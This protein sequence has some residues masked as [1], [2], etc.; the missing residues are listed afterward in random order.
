MFTF[1]MT[2]RDIEGKPIKW[3]KTGRESGIHVYVDPATGVHYVKT[4][5]FERA[6]VRIN[7][8]GTPYTEK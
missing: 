5:L 1:S 8:D 7:A 3:Y 4:S 6:Q 2:E